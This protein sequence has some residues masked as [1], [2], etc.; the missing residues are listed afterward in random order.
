MCEWVISR[1]METWVSECLWMRDLTGHFFLF[2]PPAV[3]SPT[4]FVCEVRRP[5]DLERRGQTTT[6]LEF[7]DSSQ[8]PKFRIS[9]ITKYKKIKRALIVNSSR[10]RRRECALVEIL[11]PLFY[12]LF[13]LDIVDSFNNWSFYLPSL[14]YCDRW[15]RWGG[16]TRYGGRCHSRAACDDDDEQCDQTNSLFSLC[17]AAALQWPLSASIQTRPPHTGWGGLLLSCCGENF[18]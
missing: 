9:D 16:W 11:F 10:Y 12:P 2:F 17:T 4:V 18:K 14:P 8:I 15:S 3:S 1:V 13:F 7:G 6:P 5:V